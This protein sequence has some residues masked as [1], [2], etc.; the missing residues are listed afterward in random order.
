MSDNCPITPSKDWSWFNS[1]LIASCSL[2]GL[3]HCLVACWLVCQS[4]C[5]SFCSLKA[6]R[7]LTVL[8]FG[9]GVAGFR[10]T[11][12]IFPLITVLNGLKAFVSGVWLSTAS[13]SIY[14]TGFPDRP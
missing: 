7:V 2:A 14:T 1:A 11:R 9:V 3:F 12:L 13:T 6:L 4:A 10:G 5:L 8:N